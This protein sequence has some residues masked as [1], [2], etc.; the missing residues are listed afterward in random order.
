MDGE[1]DYQCKVVCMLIKKVYF[2]KVKKNSSET[3]P[4]IMQKNSLDI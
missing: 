2:L 3:P 4:I 1:E